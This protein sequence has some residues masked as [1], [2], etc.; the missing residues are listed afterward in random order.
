MKNFLTD[1]GH[2]AAKMD[3]FNVED[4]KRTFD[5]RNVVPMVRVDNQSTTNKSFSKNF[6]GNQLTKVV[7]TGINLKGL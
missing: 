3:F 2:L 4:R 7:G 1:R 6:S 5:F